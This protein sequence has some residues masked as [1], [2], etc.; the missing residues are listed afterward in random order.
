VNTVTAIGTAQISGITTQAQDSATAIV[1]P[2]SVTCSMTL[3]TNSLPAG[4]VNVPIQATVTICNTGLGDLN[5]SI[6]GLPPI[7]DCGT[8]APITVP[9][10]FVPAGQCVTNVYCVL[11]SCPGGNVTMTVQGTAVAST[12]IPCIYDSFGNVITTA[13]STCVQPVTCGCACANSF[14]STGTAAGGFIDLGS[15][16][17]YAVLGLK[18]TKIKNS[19]VTITG[20]EG[21]SQGGTLVNMAPSKIT[22]NVVE[23]A[24]GQYSGPGT[25]G[26]S[27]I[28]APA[29]LTQNDADALNASATAA[30]L[31]PDFTF[32]NISTTKTVTATAASRADGVTVV[33]INGSINLNNGSLILSGSASDVFVVNVAGTATFVGKGGL[34]LANGVTANHVLYNFTGS[35]G[36][37]TS[38]VGNIFY[39]TLLAPHFSFNL[40]GSFVGEI[41]GGGSSI[42]LLSNAKVTNPCP[43]Q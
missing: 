8:L 2:I 25:L 30:A 22:G 24:S 42:S 33:D 37:I 10:V 40:D 4:S 12:N 35:S 36:T 31:T 1:L 13:P 14:N 34:L 3:N 15:A 29:T 26:G 5:V 23:Y 19:L 28:I 17:K 9:P 39:G 6:S 27:V 7:V 20:N 41:I 11:M 32:G 16:S 18:N 38:H 21:V 43:C